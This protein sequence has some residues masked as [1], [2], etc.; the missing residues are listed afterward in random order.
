M[1]IQWV[2]SKDSARN[3]QADL[4]AMLHEIMHRYP[5]PRPPPAGE[6]PLDLSRASDLFVRAHASSSTSRSLDISDAEA[7]PHIPMDEYYYHNRHGTDGQFDNGGHLP[8][9]MGPSHSSRRRRHSRYM[10]PAIS[11]GT[12]VQRG[13]R[14]VHTSTP[15]S[16]TPA[17]LERFAPGV[18]FGMPCHSIPRAPPN[19]EAS[20]S[21]TGR[22]I[23]AGRTNSDLNSHVPPPLRYHLDP[24][25]ASG[26]SSEA[27]DRATALTSRHSSDDD[28]VAAEA[29]GDTKGAEEAKGGDEEQGEDG[30]KED[31]GHEMDGPSAS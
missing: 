24:I 6:P 1:V 7:P 8:I 20:E 9:P 17:D 5:A 18:S 15:S 11:N 13:G 10:L 4:D 2:T 27:F 31:D 29:L 12:L 25:P 28:T 23:A 26:R 21:V 30:Q 3:R 16:F 19:S 22:S 14:F